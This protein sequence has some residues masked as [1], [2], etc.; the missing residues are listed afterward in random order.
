VTLSTLRSRFRLACQ[1]ALLAAAAALAMPLPGVAAPLTLAVALNPMSLPLFV[2]QHEGYFAAEGLA[3]RVVDCVSGARCLAEVLDGSADLATAADTPI[4]LR[5]FGRSDFVVIGSF[6]STPEDTKMLVRKSSGLRHPSQLAGRRVGV[7]FGT[8][9]Q[10]FLEAYLMLH[11]LDPAQVTAVN[12]A[13]QEMSQAL[14]SGRVDAL[15]AWEPHA[16][17]TVQAQAG[18]V[19]QLSGAGVYHVTFN[20]VAARR[21]AGVR[22]AE[23]TAMLRA[24]ERAERLI[25]ERPEVAQRILRERL[26]GDQRFVDWVWPGLRFRLGLEQSLLTTLES[27]ARWA[28]R[29]GHVTGSRVPNYLRLLHSGPLRAVSPESVGL[30]ER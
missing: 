6:A 13:P 15:A 20:L 19:L 9:G 4:V 23:L 18:D 17:R 24:V 21:L 26:G 28:L 25:H 3:L 14:A 29:R 30:V 27:E 8:S 2:A 5:S 16:W 11:G 10:Y 1:Q 7:A 22:D 12:V